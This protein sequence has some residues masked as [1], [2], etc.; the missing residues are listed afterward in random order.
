MTA[1]LSGTGNAFSIS[2]M[3]FGDPSASASNNPRS[4]GTMMDTWCFSK[5]FDTFGA[6]FEERKGVFLSI[7]RLREDRQRFQ[8]TGGM[9]QE[10]QAFGFVPAFR[11]ASTGL[12][13]LSR[14]SDGRI[15]PMHLLDGLPPELVVQ[16]TTSGRVTA[17]RSSV[18]AGFVKAGVFYTRAQA[19]NALTDA[20]IQ[21]D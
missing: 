11:D 10:N 18:T 3:I 2:E 4:W 9:S 5:D 7:H 19:A 12:V 1:R 16:R 15:A 8:D 6:T 13:Y 17:V 21:E 14:F 20:K